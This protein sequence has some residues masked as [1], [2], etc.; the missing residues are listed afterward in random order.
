MDEISEPCSPDCIRGACP[1]DDGNAYRRISQQVNNGAPCWHRGNCEVDGEYS[2]PMLPLVRDDDIPYLMVPF[3]KVNSITNRRDY[4]VDFFVE[5]RKLNRLFSHPGRFVLPF[6]GFGAI[7]S[8]DMSTWQAAP[9]QFGAVST[10]NNRAAGLYF[11]DRGFR[12]IPTARWSHP[13]DYAHCFAGIRHGSVVAVSNNGMWSD[14][15][16]RESF[17]NGLRMLCDKVNP[18]A[19]LVHGHMNKCFELQ[20]P[21]STRLVHVPTYL[22][23]VKAVA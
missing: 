2:I 18:A 21:A 13:R 12:V 23:R 8:P 9:V 3:D 19:I 1:A 10:W 4:A 6:E 11:S 16:L 20:T 5:D 22:S 15:F 7:I 17:I 14:E